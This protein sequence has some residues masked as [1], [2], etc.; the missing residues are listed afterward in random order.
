ML[1]QS[2]RLQMGLMPLNFLFRISLK[3]KM[4]NQGARMTATSKPC[5]TRSW[6]TQAAVQQRNNR[7]KSTYIKQFR[8]EE[9]VK[10]RFAGL[11][12]ENSLCAQPL[13]A[14]DEVAFHRL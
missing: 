7:V 2:R 10:K 1:N 3:M 11:T 9:V 8:E 4:R 14:I 13:C 6:R 5:P 12:S